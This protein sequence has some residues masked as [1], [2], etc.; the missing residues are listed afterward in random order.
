ME[1][2][3]IDTLD[4]AR[5]IAIV[6]VLLCHTLSCVYGYEFI[7][8]DGWF[9]NF[10]GSTVSSIVLFPLSF[11]QG[12]VALFFVISGF[13]IHL[14]FHQQGKNWRHFFI[15]RTFRIYPAYFAAL[16]LFVAL[17]SINHYLAVLES[18]GDLKH[19]LMHLLL[20]HNF[21]AETF[22]SIN[23]AF[24]S[25]AVEA[26]LYVL[27][28][29]LLS[30]I[31]KF[32]WRATMISLAAVELMS[33]E[34]GGFCY[35]LPFAY[36]F[37]WTLGARIAESFIAGNTFP[38]LRVSPLWWGV[39]AITTYLFKPL[40][41]F[42]FTAWALVSAASIS[43]LL[44]LKGKTRMPQLQLVALKKLGVWSYSLYLLHQPLQFIYLY[45][46]TWIFPQ[47]ETSYLLGFVLALA[48]WPAI[49]LLS[50]LWHHCFERPGIEFGKWLIART[51]IMPFQ[52]R[53]VLIFGVVGL[54][55]FCTFEAKARYSPKAAP[56]ENNNLAWSFATNPASS[57]RDGCLAVRYAE[58]ACKQTQYTNT[59]MVGTLAAAYA[60]A[61][62]FDDAVSTA[63][64][65][66][67]LASAAGDLKLFERNQQLLDLYR[68]HQTYHESQ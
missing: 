11:G 49:I 51:P 36:W 23:G 38:F 21:N 19:F 28:P 61:G 50:I 27:Y 5:G 13:C 57:K 15:R 48:A 24:W 29:V 18:P 26:Q 1:K 47:S 55:L 9:R 39:L 52:T 4:Y 17:N 62:R 30:A 20:I 12:G 60:E 41:P 45:V 53:W 3:H 56:E 59:I 22:K 35:M 42:W 16:T 67:E 25:L 10:D 46:L 37:S 54:L 6:A 7:P 2:R 58:A 8:W 63:G 68:R 33:A 65:A 40:S 44:S 32:G 66:C 34:V 31:S 14:S 64:K 43:H